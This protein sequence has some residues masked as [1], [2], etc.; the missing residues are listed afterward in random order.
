MNT[1][2]ARNH[3]QGYP[4][5]QVPVENRSTETANYARSFLWAN[6]LGSSGDSVVKNP[7]ANTEDRGEAGLIPGSGRSPGVGSSNPL[8]Y[9]Y[10]KNSMDRG[11]WWALF[12]GVGGGPKESGMTEQLS[13]HVH[14][15][16]WF[17]YFLHNWCPLLQTGLALDREGR[18]KNLWQIIYSKSPGYV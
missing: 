5:A 1:F 17:L 8:Q 7:P 15:T 3:T 12:L 11:A 18:K 2:F 4:S 6:T 14:P 13:T 9:S 10:L 16:P